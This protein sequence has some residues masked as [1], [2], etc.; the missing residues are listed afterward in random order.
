MLLSKKSNLC[1][2]T[3]AFVFAMILPPP[4]SN[5]KEPKYTSEYLV[6]TVRRDVDITFPCDGSVNRK[7]I[8]KSEINP[9][10]L[11]FPTFSKIGFF[12]LVLS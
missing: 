8:G 10:N 12:F 4:L 3:A 1:P 2:L 6:N 9:I 11:S 5:V 7:R